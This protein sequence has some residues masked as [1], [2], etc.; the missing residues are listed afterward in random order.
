[1]VMSTRVREAESMIAA[2]VA[3]IGPTD[4]G[5]R[6]V[7]TATNGAPTASVKS[8]PIVSTGSADQMRPAH[9]QP[10]RV[11]QTGIGLRDVA[12]AVN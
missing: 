2:A 6:L 4:L 9:Q 12:R 10:V 5:D 11:R 8:N 3:I 1:M 7:V